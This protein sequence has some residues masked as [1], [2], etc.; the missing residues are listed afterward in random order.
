MGPYPGG[1]CMLGWSQVPVTGSGSVVWI[2]SSLTCRSKRPTSRSSWSGPWSSRSHSFYISGERIIRTP[3]PYTRR[4]WKLLGMYWGGVT[5]SIC[6]ASRRT[7]R[8]SWCGW[9][10]S[11]TCWWGWHGRRHRPP[12]SLDWDVGF[13]LNAW[14]LSP[15]A[16]TSHH[17]VMPWTLHICCLVRPLRCPSS[18]TCPSR[19]CWRLATITWPGSLVGCGCRFS[20]GR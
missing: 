8:P 19:F 10:A 16:L 15:T 7:I 13:P 6:I 11:G 1:R 4:L 17:L 3:W 20:E 12:I 2:A 9:N 14:Y 5:Q 18:A